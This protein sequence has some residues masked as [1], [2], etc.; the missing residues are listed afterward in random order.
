MGAILAALAAIG[1]VIL[2]FG[3]YLIPLLIRFWPHLLRLLALLFGS[4]TKILTW[5]T[6]LFGL[7]GCDS[8]TFSGSLSSFLDLL[9]DGRTYLFEK[10]AEPLPEWAIT[11]GSFINSVVPLDTAM[12]A[13]ALMFA[14]E[15][16]AIAFAIAGRLFKFVMRNEET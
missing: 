9:I 15:L 1:R 14:V 7:G 3:R 11:A 16:A 12:T 4:W 10:M 13:I 2:T 8:E 6:V 5:I